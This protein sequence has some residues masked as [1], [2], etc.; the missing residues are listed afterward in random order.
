MRVGRNHKR[1]IYR[2]NMK[3]VIWDVWWK[4]VKKTTENN[5]VKGDL[6]NVLNFKSKII[7]NNYLNV[8]KSNNL[9]INLHIMWLK[10]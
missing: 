8:K 1:I 3:L 4:L 10:R 9:H 2:A 6:G 5:Y 7:L